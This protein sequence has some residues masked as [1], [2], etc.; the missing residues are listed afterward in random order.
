MNGM[1]DRISDCVFVVEDEFACS[2][3]CWISED[4]GG[5]VGECLK[6]GPLCSDGSGNG[7]DCLVVSR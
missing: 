3:R 7:G 2:G 6:H 4:R 1:E 5:D